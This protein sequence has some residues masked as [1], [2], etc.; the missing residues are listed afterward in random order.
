MKPVQNPWLSIWRHPR[1]TIRER[2]EEKNNPWMHVVIVLFGLVLTFENASN[3]GMADKGS[4]TN[5]LIISVII[6]LISGYIYWYLFS[7][8]FHWT[9]RW[10]GG[11]AVW[12][13]MRTAVAWASI[14]YAS[15]LILV[16]IQLAVLG[17]EYLSRTQATLEQYPLFALFLGLTDLALSAWYIYVLSNGI[18]EVSNFS[19]WRGL[20][21]VLL[22]GLLLVLTVVILA[23]LMVAFLG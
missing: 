5:A 12:E 9:S 18:A 8:V 7:G 11:R 23:L 20:G 2:V 22:G 3:Q 19:A 14:P 21:S 16:L 4:F 10:L 6:G 15:K 1:E 13:E 17:E